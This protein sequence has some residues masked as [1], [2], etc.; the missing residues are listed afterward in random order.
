LGPVNGL[1]WLRARD[2]ELGLEEGEVG[3]LR[4]LEYTK[5]TQRA[6]LVAGGRQLTGNKYVAF[7][8]KAKPES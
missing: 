6:L 2:V 3:S 7:G 4:S 8:K 1:F 5:K